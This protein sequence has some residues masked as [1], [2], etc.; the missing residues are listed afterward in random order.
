MIR[1]VFLIEQTGEQLACLLN[2]SDLVFR[3]TA[4]L[5]RRSSLRGAFTGGPDTSDEPLLFT[6]G[7]VTELDLDLLFDV[8]VS[9]STLNTE[10][11]RDLTRP[12]W[13]LAENGAAE[14]RLARP[15]LVRFVWGKAWNFPGVVAA[16]AERFDLFKPSG[17]PRRSWLRLKLKRID[18]RAMPGKMPVQPNEVLPEL[19]PDVTPGGP[20]P[21]GDFPLPSETYDRP[22]DD[23]YQGAYVRFDLLAFLRTGDPSA[24]RAE[25]AARGVTD[26]LRVPA[27]TTLATSEELT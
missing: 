14:G 21:I 23:D 2:P 9:G 17:V 27:D 13:Q 1:A 25:A 10:D 8:N 3:R 11:V 12:L 4:G 20:S 15:P 22:A 16:V 19:P 6:G 7:G 18:D 24:W 5:S 26:P